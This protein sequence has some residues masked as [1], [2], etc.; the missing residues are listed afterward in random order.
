M[1]SVLLLSSLLVTG[2]L[3]SACGSTKTATLTTTQ[4]TT[5]QTTTTQTSTTQV[6]TTSTATTLT[7]LTGTGTTTKTTTTPTG[8]KYGGT[9]TVSEP[10][11]PGGPLGYPPERAF[12]EVLFQQP[13]LEGLLW[14]SL[15]G[16]YHAKLATDW[17]I[18]DDGSSVTFTLRKGVLFH[19]GTEFNAQAV[20]W[21]Y[22][23]AIAAKKALNWS[24]VAVIDDYTVKVN[25]I[26]WQNS[27]LNDF[28]NEAGNF[29][30]SPTYFENNG[31]E[32]T[33]LQMIG[34]GPFKE[35]QYIRDTLVGYEKNTSYWDPGKPRVDKII[36]KTIPDEMVAQA[37][38]KSG[39]LDGMASGITPTLVSL[40]NSGMV[41]VTGVLGVAAYLPDSVHP[42]SPAANENFRMALE[43]AIDKDALIS[44]FSNGF[45]GAANQ[46]CPPTSAAYDKTLAPRSYSVAKA[47]ELL[48][49]AGYANGTT[50]N[51]YATN[52]EPAASMSTA[53][54]DFWDQIGVKTNLELNPSA[55]F[56][57]YGRTGWN[58]GFN[59]TAV[60]GP[61]DWGK[62]IY[63]LLNP[64]V[65]STSYVSTERTPEF[66]DLVNAAVNSFMRD[67]DKQKAVVDYLYQHETLIPVWNVCRAWVTQPYVKDGGFL[68]QASGFFWDAGSIWLDK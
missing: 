68:A 57:E 21:N 24:S 55:K 31:I 50:I 43:Y 62:T 44:A 38:F 29:I 51:L 30:I 1:L 32:Q 66:T 3:L 41:A 39:E 63:N 10:I 2:M 7:T 40:V 33:R 12:A 65:G 8:P 34:T 27:A 15:D 36:Y 16:V 25:L 67:P 13:C 28:S 6:V 26:K 35:T 46:Y 53:I 20:K 9:L 42:D 64:T 56:E 4:T 49:L 47:K 58:N 18:A 14:Q 54:A 17:Q 60:T 5:T 11:F 52:D 59:Y 22:D 61:S 48:G 23:L 37:A 19:D 45:F